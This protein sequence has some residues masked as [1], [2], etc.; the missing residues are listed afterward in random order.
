[1]QPSDRDRFVTPPELTQDG[2]LKAIVERAQQLEALDRQLR[3]CLPRELA[4]N[5]RL[6]NVR[7]DRL[8]FLASAPVWAAKLRLASEQLLGAARQAGLNVRTLTVKV[9]TMQSVPP[10]L[11]PRTPLSPAARDALRAAALTVN[12]PQLADQLLSLASLAEK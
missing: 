4:L 6:A 8:V 2:K 10:E 5:S 11:S 12:D 3:Q 1:M 7:A 9:A